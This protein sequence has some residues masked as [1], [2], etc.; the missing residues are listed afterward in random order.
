M[1]VCLALTAIPFLTPEAL[2]TAKAASV[3]L[4]GRDKD[5]INTALAGYASGT[6]VDLTLESDIAV[7][8]EIGDTATWTSISQGIV[9]PSGITVNLYL[10]SH[11]IIFDRP[12]SNKG[13]WQ[14]RSL[15]AI[16]NNGT[17]N[18]YS[19]SAS[20]PNSAAAST[21]ASA[22]YLVNERTNMM[23]TS[24]NEESYAY[25][26]GIRNNG[27]LTVNKNVTIYTSAN[28]E[29]RD[30]KSSCEGN[31]TICTIGIIN[32]G[33]A[34]VVVDTAVINTSAT[35]TAWTSAK[36]HA[37]SRAFAYNIYDGN[38]TVKGKSVLSVAATAYARS[39]S[40]SSGDHTADNT[41]VAYNIA[42]SNQ[43][44]V[45][46]GSL[47]YS[48]YTDDPQRDACEKGT[49]A[50]YTGAIISTNVPK[51][52]DGNLGAST[53]RA[54]GMGSSRGTQ[55]YVETTVGK[56]ANL[57]NDTEGLYAATVGQGRGP[58][59]R[60][61]DT[62]SAGQFYD[63]AGNI[64][65]S[66]ISTDRNTRAVALEN[67]A[68]TGSYRVHI[69][70][71][72][73]LNSNKS[74]LDTSIVSSDGECVGYSYSP[75]ADG[76]DVVKA[77]AVFS[78]ITATNYV[79]ASGTGLKYSS[80]GQ[81]FNSNYW[82]LANITYVTTDNCFSDADF[83]SSTM[84]GRIMCNFDSNVN[85]T[86]MATN[87][88]PVY[89][90]VDYVKK[91]PAR[92]AMTVKSNTAVYT[93]K[94][95]LAST[96]GASVR[97]EMDQSDCTADYDLD[98]TGAENLMFMK[99]TWT[100]KTAAGE[101]ISG[102]GT[103][104]TKVGTY[105]VTAVFEDDTVY[106]K[107]DVLHK[108]RE[109]HEYTFALT[110]NPAEVSRGTL[111]VNVTLTYGQ[112]LADALK[113]GSFKADGVNGEKPEGSFYFKNASDG[114][115]YKNAGKGTVDIVWAPKDAKGDYKQT[116]FTV[117]YTVQRAKLTIRPVAATAV[118]GE[119]DF[120]KAFSS[121]F[122]GLVANDNND[123]IKAQLEAVLSYT[124]LKDGNWYP[125]NA[126]ETTAGTYAIRATVTDSTIAAL[127]NYEF[128]YAFGADDNPEGILTV[129][130]RPITVLATAIG[131]AYDP[132]N[133][134]VNVRFEITEGKL[135]ADDVSVAGTTGSLGSNNAGT[136]LVNDI[137][138]STVS[139]L[140]TGGKRD[141]YAI[142][143]LLYATGSTLTVEITKATPPAHIPS[144][145]AVFYRRTQTLADIDLTGYNDEYGKWY[146]V[147]NS[148][149]PTVSAGA[150]AARFVPNNSANYETIT[151]DIPLTV[152]PTPVVISYRGEVS[153]GDG[154]PNITAYSYYAPNDPDFNIDAVTTS[155]NITVSTDYTIGSPVN[156]EGYTVSISAP[157]FKDVNGNYTFTTQNGVIT[158]KPRTI[159]FTVANAEITYG[160]NF[161]EQAVTVDFDKS[162]LVGDDTAE[163]ITSNGD[164]P[165]FLVSTKYDYTSNY[166]AGVYDLTARP[167]FTTSANYD[168][169]VVNG[170]LT[171]KKADLKI[172]A[173]NITVKYGSEISDLDRQY[174]LIGAKKGDTLIN[175][176]TSGEIVFG[177]TYSKGSV[178]NAEGYSFYIDISG[179]T[180]KNYNVS[181]ENGVITVE[182]AD[183]VISKYPTASVTYG[184]T[185]ADAVFAGGEANVNGEYVYDR[186][187]IMPAWQ[188]APWTIYTA[189]FI[190]EDTVN[191]NTVKGLNPSL[192]V[193]KKQ[194]TG[195]LAVSGN[196]MFNET[197]TADVSGLDP[198]TAGT[199]TFEWTIGGVTVG[200]GTSIKLDKESYV[201]STVTVKATATGYFTGSV[202]YETTKIA[203]TLTPVSEILTSDE[204][205]KY[206]D[207]NGLTFNGSDSVVYNG[208]SHDVTISLRASV[209]AEVRVGAITVKYNG[210]TTAP[211]AAGTYTVTID[212]ATP[213]Y[214]TITTKDG[215][216]YDGDTLVY[217]PVSNFKV[218]TLVIEKAPYTV[219]VDA[220][221]KV[222]DGYTTASADVVSEAGAVI[223]AG[224]VRDDV[225]FGKASFMFSDANAGTGKTVSFTDAVLTGASANNYKLNLVFGRG[226][227]DITP[228]KLLVK[229]NPVSR[230]Y[231]E[232]NYN[233][234]VA[235]EINNASIAP[236]DSSASIGVNEATASGIAD[237]YRAGTRRVTLTGVELS[238]AKKDNYVLEVT[239]LDTLTVQI[240]K[241][242]PSYPIPFVADLTYDAGRHLS[243]VSLGD[244]RWSWSQ[245]ARNEVPGAGHHVYQA[246][247]TPSDTA[248]YAT[249][250]YDVSFVVNKAPVVVKAA[251]F[252]VTYGDTEPTYYT[253]VTG[254]TGSDTAKTLNGFVVL[255]C[256][257][258]SDSYVGTY[259]ITV[260]GQYESDNYSFTY[261]PGSV[262]VKQRTV[263]VT[264]QAVDREY[265]PG[266]VKVTVNFSSLSNVRPG[267]EGNI[268]LVSSSVEGT[269]ATD[270]AGKKTVDYILP[271]LSGTVAQNYE[272]KILNP[273]IT[274]EILKAHLAGVVLP[275]S[276]V[277]SYGDKLA[278]ARWTSGFEG[279]DL[280]TFTMKDPMSTPKGVGTFTDVYKVVFTPYNSVNYATVEE[281]ITLTV[282]RAVLNLELSIVGS[283]SS[284]SK[285]RVVTNGI[286]ADAP[287]YIVYNWYRVDDPRD[288][289]RNAKCVSFN[290]EDYTLTDADEGKYIIVV[291]QNTADSPYIV[292]AHCATDASVEQPKMS[293]WQKILS[294]LYRLIAAISALFGRI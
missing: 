251:S 185:L 103:M 199:Y 283:L 108:N 222:Y 101:D 224:G 173:K 50:I 40:V 28:L 170:K 65:T 37:D 256:A 81:T 233:V 130:K 45:S 215:K 122:E 247:F 153:Y 293:F 265:K 157:N 57:P 13:P 168:V 198:N 202:S 83:A 121:F 176:K 127:A 96:L 70:Y 9:I 48:A 171:V 64:Y 16:V 197:L 211:T 240:L 294:W 39:S 75:L 151:A 109:A 117:S 287:G 67:G 62:I 284:G 187:D 156:A 97:N 25:L 281:Y 217:S 221:N 258:A 133:M 92:I 150:Y 250:T 183:P 43:I 260:N 274:V 158:V 155:G 210:S 259:Q 178:V 5:E 124:I 249:V 292:A 270:T 143:K 212:I 8:T 123:E 231:E 164:A 19:G 126:G 271:E 207:I 248:N 134:S 112:T 110:I 246:V 140:L 275:T 141:N 105:S 93:G 44:T 95:I 90:F 146:W 192:R 253:T 273:N 159:V 214:G 244:S 98:K 20:S 56:I 262:T 68:P 263:Y 175:A 223:L 230:E 226:T 66:S 255:N 243:D 87:D 131:R 286:P 116:T 208:Y 11:R 160:E 17:L 179:A 227:A 84:R 115:G 29:Y 147:D 74:A 268:S 142:E 219:T 99:Y 232:G 7:G 190:P 138:L 2:P 1:A 24:K 279:A 107:N 119:K 21:D 174:E 80:G 184:Q 94:P 34:S 236:T 128:G 291:A 165:K 51:I 47:D 261:V 172:K 104:P 102:E 49:Q 86:V 163:D 3:T 135:L 193:N 209:T 139:A 15:R 23:T 76:T 169:Q 204:F 137:Y 177:T 228:R 237:D 14:L 53:K 10:N 277:M 238:G 59:G 195:D 144:L 31:S 82:Q 125:Y 245:S 189:T 129:E 285:L 186:A 113:L 161:S 46:G 33:D 41:A 182:K 106:N 272:L 216:T 282:E 30:N 196:P 181:V 162:R 69:I 120:K 269:V 229:A 290:T 35:T 218:G 152:N 52:Y 154:T 206:F 266:D 235:F 201:G 22:I 72:Y 180:F 27:K 111:P 100:G 38:V 79:R 4:L 149:N 6:V 26:E 36:R 225:R 60:P 194:I 267:D 32:L 89:L 145:G 234:D 148:V 220:K 73:W 132:D 200:T 257:Y 136:Q 280:G 63:E 91:V 203:P 167:S 88:N 114:T 71:R 241:A 61:T 242:T 205:G 276:A 77:K 191:Y 254:L 278:S 12:S 239:N 213:S 166:D 85:Q 188:E 289:I 252:T 42:S 55:T 54:L 288:D 78:G 118:Y 18:V 264:A 58:N